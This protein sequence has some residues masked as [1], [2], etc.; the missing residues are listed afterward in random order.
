MSFQLT[1]LTATYNR[2]HL[3]PD[4]YASL[5]RQTCMDFVWIVIDD[6]SVDDTSSLLAKWEGEKKGF[7]MIWCSQSNSG[8]N[9]AI[10][11]GVSMVTTPYTMIVDS[12]DYLT[13]DAVEFVLGGINSISD[14][15]SMAGLAG[16]RGE[17]AFKSLN[18][19]SEN[20]VDAN[21]IERCKYG[22]EKDCCEVYRSD[23]LRSHPFF[24]WE[25][26]KFV[27]EEVVWNQLALEGWRLRWF[28]KVICIVRYQEEGLT[29]KSWNLL[30]NNPMGYAMMYNHRLLYVTSIRDKCYQIIQMISCAILARNFPYIFSSNEKILSYLLLP[31][32][33]LTAQRR[34][35][36]FDRLSCNID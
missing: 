17:S 10:N 11:K 1:I 4:L 16:L 9:R 21:N 27:P 6:G 25:G 5:C 12:D 3:L 2:A 32:G 28:N 33:W 15:N 20:Y 29:K 8:K 31:L 34:K 36:Q 18:L 23:L 7:R 35:M 26:E 19:M 13:D 24:V 30:K 22:L 14:Y